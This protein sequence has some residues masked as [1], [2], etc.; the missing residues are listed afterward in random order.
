MKEYVMTSFNQKIIQFLKEN[1]EIIKENNDK[2]KI[3]IQIKTI[4][5]ILNCS[6]YHEKSSSFTMFNRF[7]NVELAKKHLDC[8]PYSGK[9]NFHIPFVTSENKDLNENNAVNFIIS[10]FKNI[11]LTKK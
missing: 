7:D 8:N 3:E 11:K 4:Y 1:F 9:W 10:N 5:G 6:L 2:Y